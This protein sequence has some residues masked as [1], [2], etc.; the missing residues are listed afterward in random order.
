MADNYGIS[1]EQG[2]QIVE[3]L[4]SSWTDQFMSLTTAADNEDN[5][6]YGYVTTF[7]QPTQENPVPV[8]CVRALFELKQHEN[9]DGS[10][11]L[12]LDF[13]FES[14][15]V[16]H[17]MH[18]SCSKELSQNVNWKGS[19]YV[20]YEKFI[21]R[22]LEKKLEVR[23]PDTMMT[24]FERVR[25]QEEV[26]AYDDD[27]EEEDE[28]VNEDDE[29][30]VGELDL[31]RRGSGAALR[32][33]RASFLKKD[34]I[35]AL[36]SAGLP[37]DQNL[38]LSE[39]LANVFDAADEDDH[40]YLT[41]K[42]VFELLT[43][44]LSGLGLVKWDIMQLLTTAHEDEK[45]MIAYKAFVQAIPEI[46]LVV[47]ERR[48]A[49]KENRERLGK[50]QVEVTIEAAEVAY[51]EELETISMVVINEC[52]KYDDRKTGFIH[53]GFFRDC[54]TTCSSRFGRQEINMIMQIVE[55]DEEGYLNYEN[56]YEDL[57][58]L[59][60]ESIHN[61]MVE[62]DVALLHQHLVL[63]M[64]KYDL[65]DKA[66]IDPHM[67]SEILLNAELLCLN[68][69][70]I[71]V[72]LCCTDWNMRN[73]VNCYDFL[74]NCC[75]IIPFLFEAESF[76]GVAKRLQ[77]QEAKLRQEAELAELATLQGKTKKNVQKE[78]NSDDEEEPQEVTLDKE[79]VEKQFI[80][81]F[82]QHH[83]DSTIPH[84][85]L[86][87]PAFLNA[88]YNA[89]TMR[90][91]QFS[92]EEMRGF[93]AHVELTDDIPGAGKYVNFI[94]HVKTWVG[95]TFELR[96]YRLYEPL[97]ILGDDAKGAT[98]N[99]FKARLKQMGIEREIVL[100]QYEE[101][102]PLLPPEVKSAAEVAAASRQLRKQSVRSSQAARRNSMNA[103]AQAS[104]AK[105]KEYLA[106]LNPE[107]QNT[108]PLPKQ[109]TRRQSRAQRQASMQASSR[110]SIGGRRGT[111]GG[112]SAF[113]GMRLGNVSK[114]RGLTR[115]KELQKASRI[116]EEAAAREAA[117]IL[118]ETE[119]Q[120]AEA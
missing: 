88:S 46:V 43:A 25:L 70:Q 97:L 81:L 27:E 79:A 100:D 9:E 56:L 116:R 114:Q 118:E 107:D 63:L 78:A 57:L 19:P 77:D 84:G 99:L 87:M 103:S 67:L 105:S 29:F 6:S 73:Q 115:R 3:G 64:R 40:G 33:G 7:S 52:E 34:L 26:P 93:I 101:E 45:G 82:N 62:T 53:R 90:L 15:A 65:D 59:R 106:L 86:E 17:S 58:T 120:L 112:G 31:G 38:S 96:R 54:L 39:I 89:D 69:M 11:S 22:M 41:H 1:C 104:E 35:P 85:R 13:S 76:M 102:F 60:I 4:S 50:Q 92:R 55:D 20:E 108:A 74:H 48:R 42:E 83:V 113:G 24:Q 47:R 91:V 80:Q 95:I 23:D 32:G 72:I 119:S 10:V 66:V 71:H 30:P 75:N 110:V 117:A 5:G 111:V 21:W 49:A 18:G 109:S 37:S 44:T 98:S 28:D 8:A 36:E 61:A 68:R 12:H 94:D 2:R 14:S 16:V 51:K